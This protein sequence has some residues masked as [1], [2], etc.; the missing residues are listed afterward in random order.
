[1]LYKRGDVWWY[2]IKHKG[3]RYRESAHTENKRLASARESAFR[4]ALHNGDVGITEK[5]EEPDE[6]QI[7]TLKDFAERFL[8]HI[9]LVCASK[10]ATVR[11]YESK[12]G[13]ILENDERLGSLRL[14]EINKAAIDGYIQRRANQKSRRK[15]RLSPGSVNRELATLKRLLNLA[16]EWEVINRV[17]KI[18]LLPGEHGR[19]F[20]FTLQQEALYLAAAYP[21]LR[22]IG[23]FLIDTGLRI[24][25]CLKLDWMAVH[26]E[27]GYAAITWET[28]KNSR[29][30]NVPLTDRA[31]EVLRRRGPARSGL[32]F[33]TGD[34]KPLYQTYLNQQHAE[35]RALL[36][37]PPDCVP[38]SFRHT[39]G[40]R[41]KETGTDAFTIMH[42][43]GHSS[44][45]VS[46]RY[47]KATPEAMA[48]AVKRMEAYSRGISGPQ[49]GPQPVSRVSPTA[50][51]REQVQ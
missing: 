24:G 49:T 38:H 6:P 17:P 8:G 5:P 14:D 27:H 4:T 42:L 46:Q 37:L 29:S 32:V 18:E 3:R 50:T 7:P 15:K 31:V 44:V 34:G 12:L 33:H 23:E 21:D 47:V 9:R 16:Q 51:P 30:R 40:T 45:T 43:M 39:Y 41:L 48:S 1:M 35:I 25:E 20:F 28:T 2:Q 22:D 11:F 36:K 19:E 13:L 26:I 10:P